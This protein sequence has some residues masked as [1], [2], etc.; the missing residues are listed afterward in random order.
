[1]LQRMC[2][3]PGDLVGISSLFLIFAAVITVRAG[4]CAAA[5]RARAVGGRPCYCTQAANR[6]HL[7]A[8]NEAADGGDIVAQRFSVEVVH[9]IAAAHVAE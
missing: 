1:M 2:K 9:G 7:Y 4:V 3:Q 5:A 6:L 8:E